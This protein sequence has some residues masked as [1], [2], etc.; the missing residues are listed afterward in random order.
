MNYQKLLN[1]LKTL[2]K[3][4]KVKV[5]GKTKF[6]RN[7]FAVERTLD[8]SFSTAIFVCSMHARENITTDVVLEMIKQ[9]L[10]DEIKDFN[11]AFILMANPDGVDLQCG[12]LSSFPQ[13]VQEKLI[14][15]NGGSRDFSMWKANACGVDLNNNFDANF[16]KNAHSFTPASHGFIG[17][18]AFSE[19]ESRAIAKYTKCKN[20]FITIS[21]HT[22]GEEIY[23]NFFQTGNDLVR[24]EKIAKRFSGS[25][26]YLIKNVENSSSGGYKDWCVQKLK[27][28]A[29]TIELGSD[30]LSHPIGKEHLT[31]IFDRNKTI[32]KDLIFAYNEFNKAKSE[33]KMYNEKFMKKA[34][35]LAKKA[36]SLDEVPVGAVIVKDG[37]IIASGFNKRETSFDATN[38]AE[39]IAIKKACRKL[40]DFRLLGTEMYVTLEPCVMC[41]GAILNSRIDTVYFGAYISN[42]SI[43]ANEIVEK[44]E[45]NHKTNFV[46][47][48]MEKENSMLITNYFKEKRKNKNL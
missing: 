44:A 46:G 39:I 27:I 9:N 22:K 19:M 42:G 45:L 33:R 32:A 29:L 17:K 13:K 36:Y 5:I 16:G 21:Y 35:E 38:H 31:E 4:Y 48:F 41:T 28:P 43:S 37:K 18:H 40:K 20:P 34:M 14:L 23:F 30:D 7:I 24:D 2:E 15:I 8:R 1:E 25:M 11:L 12:K 26:G 3:K 47:G 6:N 10:F